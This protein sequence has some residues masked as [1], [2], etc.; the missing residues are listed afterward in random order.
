[1]EAISR[2]KSEDRSLTRAYREYLPREARASWIKNEV[3][4][5]REGLQNKSVDI[6][7]VSARQ[8]SLCL[9]AEYEDEKAILAPEVTGLPALRRYLF[10]L[11][12]QTNYRTLH[13]HVFET[14]PDIV[15]QVQRILEKVEDNDGHTA[16]MRED[17]ATQ[18]PLVRKSLAQLA[19]SLPADTVVRPFD[20]A[21]LE[22]SA[23][24]KHAVDNFCSAMYH[25]TFFKMVRENGMPLNGIG[26]GINFNQCILKEMVRSIETWHSNMQS[27]TEEV[28]VR[29]DEPIQTILKTVRKHM[30]GYDGDSELKLRASELLDN[31]TR[32]IG[33]SYG[34]AVAQLKSTLHTTH[35]RYTTED[36]ITCPIAL[37]MKGIYQSVLQQWS[38]QPGKGSYARGRAHILE[39][40]CVPVP[41]GLPFPDIMA[42]RIVGAQTTSWKQCCEQYVTEAMTLLQDFAQAINQ[43]LDDG[44]LLS[45]DHRRIRE[46]LHREF[47]HFKS[48]LDRVRRHFPADSVRRPADMSNSTSTSNSSSYK[49]K[50]DSDR[51]ATQPPGVRASSTKRVKTESQPPQ[52][53]PF[54]NL[55]DEFVAR[56][57]QWQ[58][59]VIKRDPGP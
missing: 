24:L 17:L 53:L 23:G 59:P 52:L 34:K 15:R 46:R 28:A 27:R 41:P 58:K 50:I 36:N 5:V 9:D 19:S 42:H 22:I 7:A 32:R 25:S 6:L 40:L 21:K 12:S 1:M 33:M 18:L 45:S 29:L 57:A 37:E 10:S 8:Y 4:V 49:R 39:N 20:G 54:A 47:P 51:A 14:L 2:Q 30:D 48:Q 26:R 13:Y 56:R 55:H 35:F 38:K 16:K 43:L 3:Q 31:A 11:P 44:A